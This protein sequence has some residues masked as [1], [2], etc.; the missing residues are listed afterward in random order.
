MQASIEPHELH[1]FQS[2]HRSRAAG[3]LVGLDPLTLEHR[4]EEVG[5]RVIVLLVEGEVLAVFPAS[6][7]EEDGEVLVVVVVA[8]A[9]VAAVEDL[10]VIEQRGNDVRALR[11]KRN[12]IDK[13]AE[14]PTN[15]VNPRIK[16][17]AAKCETHSARSHDRRV[18]T[19]NN[20]RSPEHPCSGSPFPWLPES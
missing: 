5:Q 8:V 13:N 11:E 20:L 10:R 18:P 7:G 12:A 14:S 19:R 2:L 9:E 1:R 6:A 4:D 3:E 15:G 17:Y 16:F